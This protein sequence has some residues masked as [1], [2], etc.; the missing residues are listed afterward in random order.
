M[1]QPTI[2]IYFSDGTYKYWTK[3]LGQVLVKGLTIKLNEKTKKLGRATGQVYITYLRD[4]D[5]DYYTKFS[6]YDK[7]DC[8]KKI[9]SAIEPQ[10]LDY[11][12]DKTS[13]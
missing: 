10:L 13:N 2:K 1:T 3:S 12:Y 7:A 6:F 9:K 8:L 4:P 5:G 11:I